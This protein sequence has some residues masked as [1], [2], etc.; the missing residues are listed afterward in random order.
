MDEQEFLRS[1]LPEN[2]VEKTYEDILSEPAKEIGKLGRDVVKTA[3]LFLAPFQVAASFQDQFER[4]LERITNRVPEDRRISPPPEVVGPSLEHM[5]FL[6]ED[7]PLWQMF[8]ELLSRSIDKNEIQ[9]IHPSFSHIITQ[10]SRDEAIILY[11]LKD[12]TFEVVDKMDLN[13]SE[14]RF[15]NRQIEQSNLPT[16]DLY[17]PEKLDLYYS[18]LESLSL[19]SWPVYKQD[20][21]RDSN[22]K[23]TGIRRYSRMHITEFGRL[24]IDACIPEQGFFRNT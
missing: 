19:V 1:L 17:L 10:L 21:I 24:F 4:A 14:N 23:Q 5:K 22:G 15:E 12:F 7:N 9:T 11:R 2:L 6:E 16:K 3:R 18:H 13:Q 20:P 8:E